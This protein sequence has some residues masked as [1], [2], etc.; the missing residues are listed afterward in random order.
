MVR[1]HW[2]VQCGVLGWLWERNEGVRGKTG[3]IYLEEVWSS[4]HSS[5]PGLLS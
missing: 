5:T 1:S 2:E 4:V 3:G